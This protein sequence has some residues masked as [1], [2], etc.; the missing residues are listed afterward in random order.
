MYK[1]HYFGSVNS[2][3]ETKYITRSQVLNLYWPPLFRP[4]NRATKYWRDP[5]GQSLNF[6][7]H[8]SYSNST[9]IDEAE[10]ERG[11]EDM[12]RKG[13]MGERKMYYSYPMKRRK[14]RQA[15]ETTGGANNSYFPINPSD[16]RVPLLPPRTFPEHRPPS[17][18]RQDADNF[19][20]PI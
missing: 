14:R 7:N 6:K 19:P 4:K 16:P 20:R 15:G 13:S 12:G 1:L 18:S 9:S 2:I 10:G 11:R 17:P 8:P 5:I 3:S